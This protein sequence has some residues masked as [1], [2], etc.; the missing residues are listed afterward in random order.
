[1]IRSARQRGEGHVF[2]FRRQGCLVHGESFGQAVGRAE[3]QQGERLAASIDRTRNFRDR[4]ELERL[5]QEVDLYL[6]RLLN[7]YGWPT[8]PALQTSFG[9]LLNDARL[10]FCAGQ[11]ALKAAATPEER[12]GAASLIDRGLLGLGQ[13]QWYGTVSRTVGRRLW[14]QPI[15]NAPDVD[16]RRAVLGLPP[17]AE[18][19]AE[20]VAALPAPIPP[21]GLERPVELRRVCRPFTAQAALNAPLTET[22]MSRLDDEAAQL[23]IQD[24][25]SRLDQ[26]GARNMGAVDAES[27]AWLKATLRQ[28]GWPSAN[29]TNPDLAFQVWLLTQ[30]ADADTALQACVLDLIG[31]QK[32]TMREEQSFA[33]LTDRVRLAQAQPQVYGTQVDYDAAQNR[34]APRPLQ[35]PEH[36]NERRARIGLEPIEDYLEVFESP[37]R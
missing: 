17:L 6:G 16:L 33:Y 15:D 9:V 34:A 1:M 4:R 10:Q 32:S 19:Q 3:A 23:F 24:Q 21:L 37:L 29:R 28:S 35:D 7:R 36:V 20:E 11:A 8:D 22:Q 12:R 26:P 5:G 13:G 25:A 18:A 30:H 14:T 2:A 27:T 31:Q